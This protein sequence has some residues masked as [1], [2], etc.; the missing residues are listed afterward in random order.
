MRYLSL[1]RRLRPMTTNRHL[2]SA[3]ER[4]TVKNILH[5][6]PVG[7][8]A[9]IADDPYVVPINFVY[10][11]LDNS[12]GWGRILFHSGKGKKSE[13]LAKDARVC[14]AILGEAVF[15]RG[16][17]PCGDGFTYRS[18]LVEGKAELLTGK[19]EREQALRMI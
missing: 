2:L 14:L 13:A 15:D 19:A 1:K 9:V 6:V 4:A 11:S 18:A 7:Y 3:Q 16:S 5:Q 17:E 12:D 10:D 8:L